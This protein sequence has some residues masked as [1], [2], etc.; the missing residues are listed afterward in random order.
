MPPADQAQAEWQDQSHPSAIAHVAASSTTHSPVPSTVPPTNILFPTTSFVGR[1]DD[2]DQLWE[3]LMPPQPSLI[4]IVGAGGVGKTR[5]SLE[6]ARQIRDTPSDLSR[7][8]PHFPDGLWFVDLSKLPPQ[9]EEALVL[10]ELA[11][12]LGVTVEARQTPL[13]T[14]THVLQEKQLLLLLDNCEHLLPACAQVISLLTARC[15]RLKILTTSREPLRVPGEQLFHL[16]P[17]QVFPQQ[18][19]TVQAQDAAS[20]EFLQQSSA[21]QLFVERARLVQLH[22]ALTAEN[23]LPIAHICQRVDGLP[24]AIELAAARVRF[25]PPHALLEQMT[26]E[27]QV[28]NLLGKGPRTAPARLSTLY[29]T[30]DWSYRLLESD[31]E[32]H[33]FQQ[34]A[35]FAGGA[36]LE[37]IH[38]V[39]WE[40]SPA[41]IGTGQDLLSTLEALYQKNLITH[42]EQ[43]GMRRFGMLMTIQ[44]Y[45]LQQLAAAGEVDAVRTRHL[46]AYTKLVQTTAPQFAGPQQVAWLDRLDI[47]YENLRAALTWALTPDPTA[48]KS[49]E[50]S[51][52]DDT[53]TGLKLFAALRNFWLTRS[54]WREGQQWATRALYWLQSAPQAYAPRLQANIYAAAGLLQGDTPASVPLLQTALALYETER[55]TENATLM[56]HWLLH[57][58]LALRNWEATAALTAELAPLAE[59]LNNPLALIA[60]GRAAFVQGDLPS[61]H[62]YFQR[63]ESVADQQGNRIGWVYAVCLEGMLTITEGNGAAVEER[64]QVALQQ[65]RQLGHKDLQMHLC[66]NLSEIAFLRQDDHTALA[67]IHEGIPLARQLSHQGATLCF[68]FRSAAIAARRPGTQTT[69]TALMTTAQSIAQQLTHL[70]ER[71]VELAY[72]RAADHAELLLHECRSTHPALVASPLTIDDAITSILQLQQHSSQHRMPK[73]PKK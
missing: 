68:L 20:A 50:N 1:A 51:S 63:A 28:V 46:R 49:Q 40:G 15:S 16:E 60:L 29:N 33:L 32:R 5:L 18:E 31:A 25:L 27:Q 38:T 39:C 9:G 45:A 3:L 36:C 59:A 37:E 57:R 4:T 21:V 41:S 12:V 55:D 22:F 26:Q 19:P 65:V 52:A 56:R 73:H 23:V 48:D 35:V 30:I 34:L 69:A 67:L 13:T 61:A 6:L 58:Q 10:Q 2:L 72:Q 24:L 62:A 44:E 42:Y 54:Y 7:V 64:L 53:V 14:L 47:E 8:N 70:P 66:N 11:T 17:F 71:M 43:Q